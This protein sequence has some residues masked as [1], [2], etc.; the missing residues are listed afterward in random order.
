ME[1][2]DLSIVVHPD[3]RF[4]G[5]IEIGDERF[6]ITDLPGTFT[7]YWGRRLMDRWIWLSAT[8]FEGAPERRLEAIVSSSRLWGRPPLPLAAAYLWT[9]DGTRRGHGR[10]T[11]QRGRPSAPDP[12]RVTLDAVRIGGRRHRVV[13][14]WGVMPT[15]DLG[16]RQGHSVWSQNWAITAAVSSGQ[17][18]FGACPAP[19][20]TVTGA[21]E[22]A[23]H[24][25]LHRQWPRVVVLAVDHMDRQPGGVDLLHDGWLGQQ[26]S[27][28]RD[29]RTRVAHRPAPFEHLIPDAR[30]GLRVA[31][32]IPSLPHR[33]D[34]EDIND[35]GAVGQTG[36]AV[37][38]AAEERQR[39]P[40]AG[41]H[42]GRP[43][44]D[45]APE[46]MSEEVGSREGEVVSQGEGIPGQRWDRVRIV[47]L[48]VRRLVLAPVVVDDHAITTRCQERPDLGEVF[49]ASRVA[50]DQE[51]IAASLGRFVQLDCQ[52]LPLDP[53]GSRH[54][55]RGS[56]CP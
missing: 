13:A 25:I 1:P 50:V 12:R 22:V 20:M 31:G 56:G 44:R 24:L 53:D 15:N 7:H 16:G 27:C 37:R 21:T 23:R 8:Q 41:H 35:V 47:A 45:E 10:V 26:V 46:G 6:V 54:R 52:R 18:S 51:G 40:A 9:T 28:V 42:H 38:A 55:V 36:P 32:R 43:L 33:T 30:A 3:A 34:G 5:T 29:D 39:R 48:A 11:A 4:S 17:S 2:L 14:T 19:G 49:L